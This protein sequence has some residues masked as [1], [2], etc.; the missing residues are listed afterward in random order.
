MISQKIKK[1]NINI[2]NIKIIIKYIKM[3][4]KKI[5]Y[6]TMILV[7]LWLTRIFKDSR[8]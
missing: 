2:K 1:V 3:C 4:F 5:K 8:N 6:P 7:E